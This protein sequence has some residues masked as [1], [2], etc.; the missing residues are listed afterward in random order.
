MTNLFEVS[1]VFCTRRSDQ[2][3]VHLSDQ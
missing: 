3:G 2:V 1:F